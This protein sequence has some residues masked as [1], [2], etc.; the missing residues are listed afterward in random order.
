[1]LREMR[2]ETEGAAERWSQVPRPCGTRFRDELDDR[3]DRSDGWQPETES[4]I[5]EPEKAL[6]ACETPRWM[7]R[8]WCIGA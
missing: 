7:S 5:L 4:V 2:T 3:A 8:W 6:R 1:M